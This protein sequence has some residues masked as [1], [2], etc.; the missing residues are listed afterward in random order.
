MQNFSAVI[1][2]NARTHPHPFGLLACGGQT[3]LKENH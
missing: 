1:L 3:K 2:A